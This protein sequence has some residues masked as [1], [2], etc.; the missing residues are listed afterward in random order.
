MLPKCNQA[1]TASNFRQVDQTSKERGVWGA[2]KIQGTFWEVILPPNMSKFKSIA[3]LLL[4]GYRIN[5]IK[6]KLHFNTETTKEET[7]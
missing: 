5:V 7:I 2:A 1:H 3:I 6:K 4:H